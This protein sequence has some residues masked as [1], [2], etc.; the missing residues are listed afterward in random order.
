MGIDYQYV[1]QGKNFGQYKYNLLNINEK[2]FPVNRNREE[3]MYG[4]LFK[5]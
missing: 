1:C 4:K 3:G 5:Y 2:F